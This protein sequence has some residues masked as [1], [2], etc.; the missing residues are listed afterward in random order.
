[1]PDPGSGRAFGH[2]TA[3]TTVV[4]SAASTEAFINEAADIAD[5]L[6][7]PDAGWGMVHS[8][9]GPTPFMHMDGGMGRIG[10]PPSVGKFAMLVTQAEASNASIE[11][12]YLLAYACFSDQP[13]P[14]GEQP[15]QDFADLLHIRNRI[16]HSKGEK[17]DF[18]ADKQVSVR[19]ARLLQRLGDNSVPDSL[20]MVPFFNRITTKPV[21]RWACSAAA[22]MVQT[23]IAMVPDG[24]LKT[25]LN[26]AYGSRF[27]GARLSHL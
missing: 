18:D 19:V 10:D 13:N 9:E 15:Y 1:V 14:R 20:V 7:N 11:L 25:V 3:L 17:Y 16:M 4:F 22:A 6:G 12:K 21:A 26:V 27:R 2:D 23:V 24:D 8:S 5:Y